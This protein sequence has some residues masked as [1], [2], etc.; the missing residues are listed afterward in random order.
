MTLANLG[1]AINIYSITFHPRGLTISGTISG[2]IYVWSNGT[3]TAKIAGA[4]KGKVLGLLY[5]PDVAL[6]SSGEGGERGGSDHYLYCGRG[7]T[8]QLAG[9]GAARVLSHARRSHLLEIDAR[10]ISV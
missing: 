2:D 10:A 4:H 8:P 1:E 3:V 9:R 6:F 5:V 7:A